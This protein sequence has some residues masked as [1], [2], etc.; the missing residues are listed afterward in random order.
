VWLVPPG[1]APPTDWS[2]IEDWV[3][4]PVDD[5]E[6]AARVAGVAQRARAW[7]ERPRVDEH[8]LLWVTDQWV[9]L[10]PLEARLTRRLLTSL[11]SVVRRSELA[12]AGWPDAPDEPDLNAAM[13]SL[14]RKVASVGLVIHAV[15]GKGYLAESPNAVLASTTTQSR[16]G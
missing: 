8:D 12:R 13:K 4:L 10:S 16:C 5:G 15:A 9:A 3:R 6:M 1:A 2:D 14:R 7:R 11:R